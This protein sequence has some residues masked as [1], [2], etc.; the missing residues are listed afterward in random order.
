MKIDYKQP[1]QEVRIEL[2][3]LI[4][5]IF[6]I[7]TFFILGALALTRQNAINVDL[8]QAATGVTQM[9]EILVVSVDPVGQVYIDKDPVTAEQLLKTLQEYIRNKPQGQIVLYASRLSSYNDVV[10]VLDILRSV[11]GD[12]VALA[13]LKEGQAPPSPPLLNPGLQ[14]PGSDPF[15]LPAPSGNTDPLLLPDGQ[16]IPNPGVSPQ[17]SP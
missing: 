5:V 14:E 3:P 16:V 1:D 6:C 8:P 13:T 11:G 4:D 10:R 9:R 15:G 12:R 17:P 2:I 7:L